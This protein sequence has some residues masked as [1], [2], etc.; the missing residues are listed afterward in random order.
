MSRCDR[1]TDEPIFSISAFSPSSSASPSFPFLLPVFRAAVYGET[2]ESSH[3]SAPQIT[4]DDMCPAV[5]DV[6]LRYIH[7]IFLPSNDEHHHQ[8]VD[9]AAG[10]DDMMCESRRPA[11]RRCGGGKQCTRSAQVGCVGSGQLQR[12]VGEAA[13]VQV[14]CVEAVGG[15]IGL[16]GLV[17]HTV[18][19]G[20]CHVNGAATSTPVIVAIFTAASA[21]S[22]PAH[23]AAALLCFHVAAAVQSPPS[24][25]CD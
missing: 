20:V 1:A 3:G 2:K 24:S 14:A 7:T 9:P 5:F 4:I 18:H 13:Q 22:S 11:S 19:D 12:L 6:L 25:P 17:S 21:C 10:N 15:S 8:H 23:H 16:M